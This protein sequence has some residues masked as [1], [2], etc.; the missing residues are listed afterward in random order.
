M[1]KLSLAVLA[2]G[3]G[4][5][6]FGQSEEMKPQKYEGSTWYDIGFL[7]FKPGKVGDAKKIIEKYHAAAKASGT[8]MPEI[9]WF[10][11][12]EYDAMVVW[13]MED[14]PS[15]LEWKW[16]PR[17]IKWWKAFVEQEGSE[18]AAEKISNEFDSYIL[19]GTSNILR[20]DPN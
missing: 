16:S 13:E 18:E 8:Q 7:D 6:L 15:S 9:Y 17:G 11:T 14:G 3:M 1:K 20:K 5:F 12:G 10:E 19:R 4:M 2:L